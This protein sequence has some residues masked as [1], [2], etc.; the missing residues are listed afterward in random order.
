MKLVNEF[1]TKLS[2]EIRETYFKGE[3]H[4]NPKN[5]GYRPAIYAMECFSNGCMVYGNLIDK[6]A[7]H[8]KAGKQQVHDIV[9]KYV[10]DFEG[11]VYA[12]ADTKKESTFE[13]W[14]QTQDLE[15]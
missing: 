8:C 4:G 15:Q 11:Y 9:K 5:K 10:A 13:K 14:V 3:D 12:P 1:Y 7:R 6:L 2:A